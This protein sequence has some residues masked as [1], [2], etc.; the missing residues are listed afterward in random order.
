M[1][2]YQLAFALGALRKSPS[3][4]NQTKHRDMR[5]LDTILPKLLQE[6]QDAIDN[7]CHPL[8]IE[9]NNKEIWAL[10]DKYACGSILGKDPAFDKWWVKQVAKARNLNMI[11]RIVTWTAIGAIAIFFIIEDNRTSNDVKNM[12]AEQYEQYVQ[13]LDTPDHP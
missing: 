2:P 12:S 6:Q 5:S 3:G 4:L 1:N 9:Q 13:Q 7:D 10:R 11:K 8:F